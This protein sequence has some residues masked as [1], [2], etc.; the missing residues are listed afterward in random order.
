MLPIVP[1]QARERPRP[2]LRS[3]PQGGPGGSVSPPSEARR[4]SCESPLARGTPRQGRATS[5]E[6]S[7]NYNHAVDIFGRVAGEDYEQVVFNYDRPSGLRAI[8]A[9][10]STAL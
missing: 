9:I 2:V 6:G 7:S 5:G 10:H 8:I 3:G 1:E 4:T